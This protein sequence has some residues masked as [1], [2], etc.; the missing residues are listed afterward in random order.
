MKDLPIGIS[1]YKQLIDENYYYVDKT[2]FVKDVMEKGGAVA[3][4]PRPRRF[5]KTINLS[6]LRY[7][8]EKTDTDT[9]Y[10]FND[11][12]I[13]QEQKYKAMQGQYPV[14]FLSFKDIKEETWEQAYTKIAAIIGL[15][16]KRHQYLTANLGPHDLENF[17]NLTEGQSSEVNLHMSLFWLTQLLH[18]HY[19]KRVIVLIDEYD[20]P[21]QT[22]YLNNYYDKMVNLIRALLSTVMKDN[23][24][25]ERGVLTGILRT[26]KEGIFSG[27][28]NL[29]VNALN[30]PYFSSSFGLTEVEVKLLLKDQ[31]LSA[32]FED[33]RAWYDG[34]MFGK[35]MIYNPWSVIQC[36]FYRGDFKSYWLNTSDNKLIKR[37]LTI[38]DDSV[39]TELQLLLEEQPVVKEIDEG[40][41]F[42]G[43]EK[44]NRAIWSL[45]LWAGYVTYSKQELIEGITYCTLKI[46]N[47][48]IK[49]LY[50]SLLR[51]I[52]ESSMTPDKTKVILQAL[53]TGETELFGAL[54][55]EFIINSMSSYD[56]PSNEPEK[57]YHLFVLG[58][59]V[60]LSDSYQVKSNRESGFGR[61]DIML[62]PRKPSKI[63]II[64]EFKKVASYKKET[65]KTAAD[66]A[67]EQ[68][69]Q[70]NYAQE[71]KDHG[72]KDILFL[73]IAFEGKTV[74]VKEARNF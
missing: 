65:I 10:L 49:I 30:G 16:F 62:I 1:D 5:G 6:M 4:I 67:L 61:Y 19:K 23:S 22:A 57:S 72:V 14:I 31:K 27:L 15:E 66:T 32:I 21:V 18:Q 41:V 70:R 48:E 34:Y 69:Q 12:A 44:H 64:I 36:A 55:Q 51:D 45:L 39:K 26:A 43:I 58:L 46:P 13:W 7:F 52:F 71:L 50:T 17:T 24:F 28:N 29:T 2:L 74:L 47:K 25:L 63:G 3:L 8:F 9:S 59:L 54:L 60:L 68:I 53:I 42:P 35:T 56:L 73:G 33:V 37:L 38:A 40:I 11:K 20:A